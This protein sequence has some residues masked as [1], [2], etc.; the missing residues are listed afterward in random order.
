MKKGLASVLLVAV[1]LTGCT[2][3]SA[4]QAVA[5][6]A[7]VGLAAFD[8]IIGIVAPGQAAVYE[9]DAAAVGQAFADLGTATTSA[10]GLANLQQITTGV[11]KVVADIL[12]VLPVQDQQYVQE[13]EA[14][15]N[16]T[17]AAFEAA[18]GGS[19]AAPAPAVSSA[20]LRFQS[21]PD[22]SYYVMANYDPDSAINYAS[23]GQAAKANPTAQTT[24]PP[25]LGAFKKQFNAVAKKHNKPAVFKFRC[26]KSWG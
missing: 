21:Y 4:L 23:G 20:N 1:L 11:E 22:H 14:V 15:L 9:K 6:W 5:K 24:K 10:Q 19:S 26:R 25:K 17:V 16:V 3:G 18:L 13:G 2:A 8:G 7:P 12:P